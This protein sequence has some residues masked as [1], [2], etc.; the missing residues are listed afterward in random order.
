V[1]LDL[2]ERQFLE[3]GLRTEERRLIDDRVC[4]TLNRKIYFRAAQ[5]IIVISG[6]DMLSPLTVRQLKAVRPASVKAAVALV[7]RLGQVTDLR[8]RI[9]SLNVPVEGPSAV[10]RNRCS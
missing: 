7:A 9:G 5:S 6:D 2:R 8:S 10:E 3:H 4:L 1:W